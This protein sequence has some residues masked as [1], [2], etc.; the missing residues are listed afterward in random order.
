MSLIPKKYAALIHPNT[1]Y[2]H[3]KPLLIG[4]AALAAI[5][6]LLAYAWSSYQEWLTLGAG[7]VP[8]NIFG[9]LVQSSLHLVARDDVRDPVPKPHASAADLARA[10]HYGPAAQTSYVSASSSSTLVTKT[11][12]GSLRRRAGP[13]PEVPG[14]VAPQRQTTDWAAG[15]DIVTL[16]KQFLALLNDA[17]PTTF[18]L[19]QSGLEGPR[20]DALYL[21][22][23]A[24]TTTTTTNTKLLLGRASG[25]EWAHVHGEGSAHVT[26][27]PVDAAAAIEAGWAERHPLS[28]VGG[29]YAMVPWG[30]VML[31]AP[32][33]EDEYAVWVELVLAAARYVA[34]AGAERDVVPVSAEDRSTDIVV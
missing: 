21:R 28:G 19:A 17:N 4:T 30:Y 27:S 12:T 20:H 10:Y 14:F 1:L 8:Y 13:R 16:Q 2:T 6:P 22:P 3:R 9:W 18:A 29:G 31:Y 32:R 34:F 7:G 11:T 15:P 26:L 5:S 24:T 33:N 25:N 23:S